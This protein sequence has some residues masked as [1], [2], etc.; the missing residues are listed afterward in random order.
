MQP[1][2]MIRTAKPPSL[3]RYN[4]IIHDRLDQ[5]SFP[6]FPARPNRGAWR[7][8]GTVHFR[9]N[10]MCSSG[11]LF[12]LGLYRRN[13]SSRCFA[14]LF[15]D[16]SAFSAPSF[17]SSMVVPSLP[18]SPSDC[19]ARARLLRLR[20][21]GLAVAVASCDRPMPVTYAQPPYATPYY[22]PPPPQS[23][24]VA[25]VA[26]A[27]I[28]QSV[29]Y[30]PPGAAQYVPPPSVP[31][32][33]PRPGTDDTVDTRWIEVRDAGEVKATIDVGTIIHDA[34]G[35]AHAQVCLTENGVCTFGRTLRWFFNCRNHQYSFIDTTVLPTL[36][37]EMS[38]AQPG[39]V[40]DRLAAMAC[41]G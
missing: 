13:L 2:S 8:S 31:G 12:S 4:R 35:N 41:S 16:R 25:P 11:L 1:R 33:F 39:S 37:H 26:Q 15:L 18:E 28:P 19:E 36:P 9:P 6:A 23:V 7:A 14:I 24:P 10:D 38:N 30:A 29:Q 5:D 3:L 40:A 27:P 22:P 32:P 17:Q 20:H 34:D 21:A